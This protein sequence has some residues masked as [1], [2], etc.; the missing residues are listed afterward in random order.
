LQE[1]LWSA[2]IEFNTGRMKG[3]TETLSKITVVG[4]RYTGQSAQQVRN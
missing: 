3:M 1:N 4:D 2:D